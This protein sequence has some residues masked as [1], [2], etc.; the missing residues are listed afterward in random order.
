M[1]TIV[2]TGASGFVG[3]HVLEALGQYTEN[4]V[5]AACRDP[6][7]LAAGFTGQVKPGDLRDA[8]YRQRLLEGADIVIHAAAWS[9]LWRHQTLSRSLY[10]EPSLALLEDAVSAGVERFL[11]VSSTSVEVNKPDRNEP[12][13]GYAPGFWPHLCNVVK[14]ENAMRDRAAAT[15]MISLRCGLFA[16]AR[17]NLGLLPILL[18]RLKTHLVPYIAG[19]KTRMPIVSGEDIGQAFARA[20]VCPD[21]QGYECFDIVGPDIPTVREVMTFLQERF[22]YPGPHFSVPFPLGYAFAGF[23]EKLNPL[24]PGD[25]LVVRSIIHLLEE[26]HADNMRARQRFGYQPVVDWKQAVQ[27]QIEE[28]A[29][30]QK[31]AMPMAMPV[32]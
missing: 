21:M 12:G 20:A 8:S 11:F 31:T 1:K 29:D 18:P 23:M 9:S 15:T 32:R 30:R 7:R 27:T 13:K 25:P 10:Y 4:P 24:M 14:L 6:A 22:G 28:M 3:S 26:T 17:Y 5:I 16:G 19:G 2:V